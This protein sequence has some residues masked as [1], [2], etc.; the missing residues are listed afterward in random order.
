MLEIPPHIS[1]IVCIARNFSHIASEREAP[2]DVRMQEASIFMKPPSSISSIEPTINLHG[3]SDVIC[4]TELALLIGKGL[5]RM[6]GELS[7][8][9]IMESIAGIGLA[10]DLT[11]KELQNQLK[12]QGKPWELAKSFDGACPMSRF[13]SVSGGDWM[14]PDLDIQLYLNGE[15]QLQQQ[16]GD[17]ILPVVDLVRTITRDM[18]LWP[19]DVVLTGTPTRPNAPPRIHP[20][21]EIVASVGNYIR[22]ETVVV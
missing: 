10:F 16:I 3:Y 11:R 19:G 13:C 2:L 9:R 8:A 22:V 5:P 20:G 7:H 15:L 12:S 17:M 1:K 21:N 6:R 18:S 14:S 4:E